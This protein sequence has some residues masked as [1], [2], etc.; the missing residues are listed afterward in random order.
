MANPTPTPADARRSG[1]SSRIPE[2]N[3]SHTDSVGTHQLHTDEARTK[4]AEA[5]KA[6][7][8][9][10]NFRRLV[11]RRRHP[12]EVPTLPY[13]VQN[14]CR[15]CMGWDVGDSGSLPA[16][17]F[18]CTAPECWLYPWRNGKLTIEQE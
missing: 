5:R 14:Y 12:S 11:R 16:A 17:V 3:P 10:I 2:G 4:A 9:K 8:E 6:R 7:A 15:E 1:S 13:A 18:A